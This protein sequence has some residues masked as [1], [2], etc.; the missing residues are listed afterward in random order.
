MIGMPK[1]TV[2][3]ALQKITSR[4]MAE[5]NIKSFYNEYFKQDKLITEKLALCTNAENRKRINDFRD[6]LDYLKSLFDDVL[7]NIENGKIHNVKQLINIGKFSVDMDK[8][9]KQENC[10]IDNFKV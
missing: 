9:Y 7:F 6:D 5:K 2:N 4:V 8:K 3:E 10:D 1:N